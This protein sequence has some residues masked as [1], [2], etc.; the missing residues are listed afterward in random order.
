MI[1]KGIYFY[2]YGEEFERFKTKNNEF[3]AWGTTHI[4]LF[5]QMLDENKK[6]KNKKYRLTEGTYYEFEKQIKIFREF[7][8]QF[9]K[10]I[11]KSKNQKL[12]LTIPKNITIEPIAKFVGKIIKLEKKTKEYVYSNKKRIRN[13]FVIILD[14][15]DKIKF[16]VND[17]F[18]FKIGDIIEGE[19]V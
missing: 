3:Y 8:F 16:E 2:D 6:I 17:D 7:S 18:Q 13:Y 10:K 11:K 19:G 9:I 4:D 5:Q 1:L 14:V 15:K 12:G